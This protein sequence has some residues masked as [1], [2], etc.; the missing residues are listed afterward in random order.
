MADDRF[1]VFVDRSAS[2]YFHMY[3][4]RNAGDSVF[5]K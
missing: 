5:R 4:A 2:R 3:L 1:E